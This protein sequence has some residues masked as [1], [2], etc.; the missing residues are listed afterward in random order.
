MTMRMV[1]EPKFIKC[2]EEDAW[3]DGTTQDVT[4]CVADQACLAVCHRGIQL[5]RTLH[6]VRCLVADGAVCLPAG[7]RRQ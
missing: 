4:L 6:S 5:A 1:R 2:A 3:R 7:Q